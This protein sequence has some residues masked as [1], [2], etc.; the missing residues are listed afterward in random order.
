MKRFGLGIIALTAALTM[1]CNGAGRGNDVSRDDNNQ[2]GTV[3]TAGDTNNVSRGDEDFVKE[4]LTDGMAEV[5]LGNM[6]KDRAMSAEV[7]QFGERMVRDHSKAGDELKQIASQYSITAPAQMDDKHHELMDK[8]SKVR[9]TAFDR[10]YINA[11]VDGH[12]DVINQLQKHASE[13]RFGDNKGAVKPEPSNKASEASVNQWAA[14]ALPTVRE[15]LDQAKQ[16]QDHL[17][18]RNTTY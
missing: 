8:L 18:N 12:Q 5:E 4:M 14:K 6:A 15:H 3:G 2:A 11:M 13:D 16:I 1:A 10:E 7:K 17:K 9:G